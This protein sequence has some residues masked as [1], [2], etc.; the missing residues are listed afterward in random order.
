M[1]MYFAQFN[2]DTGCVDAWLTD[3]TIVSINCTAVER[4]EAENLYQRAELD[5]L[6]EPPKTKKEQQIKSRNGI[7]PKGDERW[8]KRGY[9]MKSNGWNV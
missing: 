6:R 7:I 1:D 3:G 5:Y 4:V 2:M 9:S 8:S